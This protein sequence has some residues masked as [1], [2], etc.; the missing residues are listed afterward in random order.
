MVAAGHPLASQAGLA[1]LGAGGTAADAAVAMAFV[2]GVVMPDMCGVGGEAFAL[3]ADGRTAPR[4]FLGSGVLPRRYDPATLGPGRLL[5]ER[6]GA[7]VAVPGAIELYGRLHRAGGHLPWSRLLEPAIALARD[8]F[9]CDA[10]LARSLVE[11]RPLIGANQAV[12]RRFYPAGEPLV[13]GQPVVQ[14]ELAKTLQILA[15]EGPNAFYGGPLAEAVAGAAQDAGGFLAADDLSAHEGQESVA[16]SLAFDGRTIWQTPPPSPGFVLLEALKILEEFHYGRDWRE[17][18]Q[19]VHRAVE[20]LQLAFSDR[21]ELAGDPWATGFDP[22]R[23]LRADWIDR[24]RSEIGERARLWPTALADGE[25]TSFVV[26]DAAGRAVSFIHSL[27]LA[28]GSGVYAGAE[29]FFLN[30][31]AGRSMNRVP[32]HPNEA[33]PGKRPMHTLNAYLV[34]EGN[35]VQIAGNTPGGDG[36]M[37]WNLSILLDL[38]R[39]HRLPHEAVGL[40]RFLL[41]PAT[42]AHRLSDPP[43]LQ[44]E[45]R[46]SRRVIE[47]LRRRGHP[48]RVVGPYAIGG[49]AQVIARYPGGWAGASDPRGS[50][51]TQG[52]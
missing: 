35:A 20:A 33:Q 24:R 36:Q 46:F 34:T 1:T 5:P 3:M 45:S 22:E 18:A 29:G 10:R 28:F 4:A 21:R 17:D 15:R 50:G 48:V 42:D 2:T 8:G 27:A 38:L 30:N 41:A 14:P 9:P 13:E 40:P 25:T 43:E 12:A 23:L 39:G 44:V 52:Y 37:Q 19:A 32:G 49:S 11:S 6:G 26:A 7:S 51:Q 47:E 16:L 31:R